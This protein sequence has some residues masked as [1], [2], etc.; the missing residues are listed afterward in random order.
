M[1]EH[2]IINC[3]LF[4][5]LVVMLIICCASGISLRENYANNLEWGPF[6]AIPTPPYKT[7]VYSSLP[8]Q[9][10]ENTVWQFGT[11]FQSA[12]MNADTNKCGKNKNLFVS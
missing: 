2:I 11:P 3:V 12:C 8:P 5:V 7:S 6:C 4:I 1:S 9:H 10:E